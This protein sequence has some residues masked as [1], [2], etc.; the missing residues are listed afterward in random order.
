MRLHVPSLPCCEAVAFFLGMGPTLPQGQ[1][2]EAGLGGW[3]GGLQS[4]GSDKLTMGQQVEHRPTNHLSER[5]EG[6]KGG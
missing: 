6:K 2:C 5:V 3:E 1:A 4:A